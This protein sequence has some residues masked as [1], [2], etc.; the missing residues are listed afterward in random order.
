MSETD[1]VGIVAGSGVSLGPLL[2]IIEWK[3]GFGEF[4]GLPPS[5]VAGHEGS[6]ARGV[7]RGR[8]LILQSGRL[9]FYEGWSYA[10]VTRTVDI[11]R[12]LGAS[13]I[14]FT[15]AAG[16]LTPDTAP[17]DLMTVDRILTWPCRGWPERPDELA[18]DI[19]IPGTRFRGTYIW[20]H[21]PNY[22]TRAEIHAFQS[23][24]AAAVGM[25][26]APELRRA[27]ELGIRS[28]VV[29]CITN[30]CCRPERLTHD[31]VLQTASQASA[32]LI[33]L[34]VDA[35]PFL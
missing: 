25:S 28:A 1:P 13:T 9:H 32:R 22:E 11:L 21:G 27:R 24:G 29:S 35:L 33:T 30:N 26:A 10:Q 5:R 18:P 8:P 14:L 6:F 4:A 31:H 16:G 20:V 17:G 3:R 19:V 23:L 2:E 12:E 15:N 7:C 34:I